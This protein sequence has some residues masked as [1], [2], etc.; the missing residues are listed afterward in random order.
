MQ[1]QGIRWHSVQLSRNRGQLSLCLYQGQNGPH[2]VRR[3]TTPAMGREQ[4]LADG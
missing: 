2:P 1:N 4:V 3:W